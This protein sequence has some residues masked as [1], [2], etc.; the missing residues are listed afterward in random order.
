M[1]NTATQ[2]ERGRIQAWAAERI[3][4]GQ[5]G[6]TLN[7]D[8]LVAAIQQEFG[9]SEERAQ[10]HA[11]RAARLA[12][13]PNRR[14][15][16]VPGKRQVLVYVDEASVVEAKQKAIREDTNLSAVVERL[17]AEWIAD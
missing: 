1:G 11:A 14:A 4:L 17:L 16:R 7:H 6:V 5:D 9:I 2:Q 10:S 8:E 3:Q 12:R 13:N 15:E